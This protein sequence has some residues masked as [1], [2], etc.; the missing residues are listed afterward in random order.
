MLVTEPELMWVWVS[1]RVAVQLESLTPGASDAITQLRAGNIGSLIVTFVSVTLPVF[2]TVKV[3][4]IVSPG[5]ARDAGLLAV[6]SRVP[7]LTIETVATPRV[8]GAVAVGGVDGVAA[9]VGVAGRGGRGVGV[10]A[11]RP[12]I[13]RTQSSWRHGQAGRD[14]VLH[15]LKSKAGSSSVR[16]TSLR[17]TLP[18]W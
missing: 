14:F 17:A 7:L 6:M 12:G 8:V 1:V 15:S 4:A 18:V 5:L 11:V 2:S 16:L 3:Y 13:S 10:L 9:A